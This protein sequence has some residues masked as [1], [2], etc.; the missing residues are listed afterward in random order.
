MD[1]EFTVGDY[2][3]LTYQSKFGTGRTAVSNGLITEIDDD[4][5]AVKVGQVVTS[6]VWEDVA[7]LKRV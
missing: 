6:V 7:G 1:T 4:H 5:I 3:I 2:V